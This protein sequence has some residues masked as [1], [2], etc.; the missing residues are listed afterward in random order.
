[1]ITYFPEPYPDELWYSVLARYKKHM[2]ITKKVHLNSDLK[3]ISSATNR[4][5]PHRLELNT[6]KLLHFDFIDKEQIILNHTLYN[7]CSF[8]EEDGNKKR[9]KEFLLGENKKIPRDFNTLGNKLQFCESCKNEDIYKYGEA[10]WHCTHQLPGVVTCYK[11]RKIL[12]KSSVNTYEKHNDL[13]DIND[14]EIENPIPNLNS[15]H[16]ELLHRITIELIKM[17]SSTYH[18]DF[19]DY[20]EKMY[21][22]FYSN[23]Y[24]DMNGYYTFKAFNEDFS[25]IYSNEL[26]QYLENNINESN[27]PLFSDSERMLKAREPICFVMIYLFFEEKLESIVDT[28]FTSPLG[29]KPFKCKSPFCNEKCYNY[30]FNYFKYG[31]RLKTF[32]SCGFVIEETFK[33][34][35]ISKFVNRY[36]LHY[37]ECMKYLLFEENRPVDEISKIIDAHPLEVEKFLMRELVGLF[38]HEETLYYERKWEEL[39]EQYP[40]APKA[41][42]KHH[43]FKLY[44]Y[45]YKHSNLRKFDWYRDLETNSIDIDWDERDRLVFDYVKNE[46]D[47]AIINLV[48]DD[49]FLTCY[50]LYIELD[51]LKLTGDFFKGRSDKKMDE[52]MDRMDKNMDIYKG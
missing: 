8:L 23:G 2:G 45:K 37:G 4:L 41:E 44:A 24:T 33:N 10:Y 13:I 1:M 22:L 48:K 43:D 35:K 20:Q 28:K 39:I 26:I 7:I 21:S 11:H 5:L 12:I 19:N 18:I 3:N 52:A 25:R 29:S 16:I 49:L 47:P 32:C 42:L 46:F 51:Y 9:L 27:S 36:G 6:S 50:D 14:A 31:I 17:N 30:E 34:N 15:R 40:G 38:S